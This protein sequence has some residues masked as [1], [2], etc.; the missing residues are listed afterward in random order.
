M[1]TIPSETLVLGDWGYA[2]LNLIDHKAGKGW[3][4]LVIR[5]ETL[6]VILEKVPY[7]LTASEAVFCPRTFTDRARLQEAVTAILRKY[8]DTFYRRAHERWD[9]Q[10]LVYHSLD[11][12]DPNLAFNCLSLQE[13]KAAYFV[14]VPRSHSDLF[15]AIEKLCEDMDKLI[16]EE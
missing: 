4:N 6:R 13:K 1:G 8:L 3:S 12:D 9:S 10:N 14:R 2:Y 16:K 5:P 15:T 7:T 11:L